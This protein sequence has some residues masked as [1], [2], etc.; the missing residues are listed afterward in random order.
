MVY[1]KGINVGWQSGTGPVLFNCLGQQKEQAHRVRPSR[2]RYSYTFVSMRMCDM[3]DRFTH[4]LA[5]AIFPMACIYAIA[6]EIPGH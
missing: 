1:V 5:L 4:L 6:A 2:V 3:W